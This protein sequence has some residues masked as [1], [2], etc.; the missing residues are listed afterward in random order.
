MNFKGFWLEGEVG[1]SQGLVLFYEKREAQEAGSNCLEIFGFS[2]EIFPG[3]E[4]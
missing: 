3:W 1:Q 4:F 2:S